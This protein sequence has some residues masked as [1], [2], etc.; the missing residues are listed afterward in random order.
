MTHRTSRTAAEST[1]DRTD[2][3]VA[4][5]E[6][7]ERT[8]TGT[9][10]DVSALEDLAA[11]E[12]RISD[13]ESTVESISDRLDDV[14]AATQAI[15]GY[16]GGVRTVNEDVERRANAA[17]AKAESLEAALVDESVSEL[18]GDE[19]VSDLGGTESVSELSTSRPQSHTEFDHP[20]RREQTDEQ[21][22]GLAAR[23]RDVL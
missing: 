6:A 5:L 10:T 22:S 8:L 2:E 20:A 16:V 12:T 19:P 9:D 17:L 23:L 1:P 14:D 3:L 21:S 11:I 7:V 18:E 4:R 15:R 13:L